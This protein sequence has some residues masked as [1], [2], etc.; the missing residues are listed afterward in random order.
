[1]R[2]EPFGG[3]IGRYFDESTPSWPEPKRAP[4]GAPNVLIVVLDD[5]GFAQ[6]GC[7]GS[8]IATPTFD[9][10][11]SEGLRYSN[12]HTTA[13]CSP[14]RSCVLTGRNHHSNGMGRVI[15]I[16][17]GYPGY[18]SRIPFAN[19]FLSEMLVEAGY[20]AYAIG[21]WHLTP[22][23]E[24][25]AGASR[26]RWPL[27]RG[28]ERFYGFMSG[29]THQF[30][31][32]LIDDNHL[33]NPPYTPEEGYHLTTD[34]VDR[35][36]G[37]VRD[38]RATDPDK[39]FFAYL[40]TGA[41]HSPH[42]SPAEWIA[43]YQG[44]F[45]GGWDQW[46]EAALQR[47]IAMGVLPEGTELSA[48][49]DW[50]PAWDA[51]SDDERRLYARFMEAFAAFLSHTD[52]EIGRLVEYLR[53]TG[54]LDNTLLFVLSDNGASSEGGPTGSLNDVRP[55]NGVTTT[56]EE[57]LAHI[58]EIGGP[59]W[60][61]NYPW[62]WTVAGNTPFRRWKR[63]VHEGGVADPLIVHWPRGGAEGG[64]GFRRQYV[65]AIDIVPTVLEAVGLEPLMEIRGVTQR[66][67]E[68]TSFFESI[69]NPSSPDAHTT[70]Y[71]EMFGCRALYHEGWKAVTYHPIMQTD[72]G[73]DADE[74]ELY[75]VAVDPSECHDLAQE[76]PARLSQMI[77]RWWV[78]AGRYQ[79]LPLDPRP[80]PTLVGER[81]LSVP[82]RQRYDYYQDAAPVP[83]LVAVNVKNRTHRI[84]AHVTIPSGGGGAGAGAE[85]VLLAQGSLLGGW[86]FYLSGGALHHVHNRAA[87]APDHLRGDVSLEPGS[88]ILAFEFA[89]VGEHRGRTRLL[90]DHEVVAEGTIDFFTPGRFSVTGAG[91]TCGYSNG[92]PVTDE[93]EP[94]FRFTGTIDAL[95]V[96]VDGEPFTD[97]SEEAEAIIAMQ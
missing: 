51:L 49:P 25:H 1:V 35:A 9:R 46:R 71:Y 57:A 21:K 41:C 45:D 52:H 4:S 7:F 59:R 48:R 91:V 30:V 36:I 54:D 89:K 24:C 65:H 66:P 5:V 37:C 2:D 81:P 61:N 8:D 11:A 34:L 58:D 95:F 88:H 44:A 70:Q 60:H 10:L 85:G 62:G 69:A 22:E 67:I 73:I 93:I 63:E 79:V 19:G 33:A 13:L 74:W 76:E 64:A 23:D 47:Q 53:H 42:Q 97:A 55:W 32:N 26:A 86:C 90:A 18:N 14:T 20:A 77:E 6:L 78:E 12:F 15:E 40:A 3:V 38:L 56:L 50:V 87:T 16:A 94:P 96:E 28:F 17:S 92:L 39:P 27:G 75:H 82:H 72:P 83:E 80:L 84:E 31:P 43:R 29:E 68:G